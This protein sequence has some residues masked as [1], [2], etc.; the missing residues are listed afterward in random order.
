[1]LALDPY[2]HLRQTPFLFFVG[3]IAV[4]A[5][6]GGIEAGLLSTVLSALLGHYYLV[7]PRNQ[8]ST[9][10][11]TVTRT[12][13]FIVQGFIISYLCGSLRNTRDN[14][15]TNLKNW[16]DSE[17]RFRHLAAKL[18]AVL[19][20]M[21]AGVLLA[22]ADSEELTLANEQVEKMLGYGFHGNAR[23]QQY[24]DIV[25]FRGFSPDGRPLAPEDWPL[26]RSLRK[27]EIV[28][29]EEIELRWPDGKKMFIEVNSGPIRDERGKIASAVAIFQDISERVAIESALR[30]SDT[31]LNAFLA[32]SPVGLAFLDRDLRYVHVNE[33]LAA[34]NGVP[35]EAHYGHTFAEILPDWASW[36]EERFRRVMETKEPIL[37]EEIAGKAT[38]NAP[39]RHC[40]INIYPVCLPD[41]EV[42]G[43]GVTGVDITELK[44]NEALARSR[45]GELETFMETVPVAV[46][47]A[48]DPACHRMTANRAAHDLLRQPQGAII[49]ATPAEGGYPFPF[50]IQKNGVDI[51][52]EEL[53]MQKAAR[54]GRAVEEEFEF[55]FAPDDIR[56]IY[57]KAVPIRDEKDN[58]RGVIGAFVDL[59]DRVKASLRLEEQAR[60]LEKLNASLT[61]ATHL[62][63]QRNRELD[64]FAH[65]VSHDL[66]APLRAIANLS[67]WIEEDLEEHLTGE[68][69]HNMNLLRGRVYRLESL[70]DGLLAY[71]R[72]GRVEVKTERVAVGELLEEV[73]DSLPVPPEFTI[74]VQLPQPILQTK[75]LPLARV[76]SNLIANAIKHHERPDGKIEIAAI[77]RDTFIEFTVTDDGPGIAPEFHDRIFGIFQTLKPRDHAENTGI[78]LS[79]VKKILD[80][81]GGKVWIDSR[82]G[83][84]ATFHFTWPD[85]TPEN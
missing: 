42:L 66:K 69:R 9:E 79:I 25:S 5:W 70:I 18:E 35:R 26:A 34:S 2:L 59:S 85:R 1:M 15:R 72:I 39:Y 65:V 80:T 24:D 48:H 50:K 40:L 67:V 13:L 21:P 30:E 76:F 54:T 77:R 44:R 43:V 28:R 74:S 3:A 19:Q 73:I 14:A 36:G 56:Y 10:I 61:R 6:Y 83:E 20:Q 46:W 63:G 71:S 17:E 47:I 62:L 29:A 8:L 84:G 75:R 55:V 38:P 11:A 51:P 45:A 7:A 22:D 78:G 68:T 31:L 58:V 16:Q 27:G 32:G 33:A 37:G 81:E 60:E 82:E 53:A 12:V 52:S 64:R 57:G 49:T 41:G 4:S 23:L